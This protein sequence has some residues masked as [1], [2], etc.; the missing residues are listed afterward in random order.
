MG[1]DEWEGTS[2][3]RVI[4]ESWSHLERRELPLPPAEAVDSEKA[5]LEE[6]GVAGEV[7][8]EHTHV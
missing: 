2:H 6:L 7:E 1:G 4:D 5:R 8:R 3:R